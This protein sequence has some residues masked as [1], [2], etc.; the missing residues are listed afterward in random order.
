MYADLV[1]PPRHRARIDNRGVGGRVVSGELKDGGA[2]LAVWV[3]GVESQLE[4]GDMNGLV[5]FGDP[6]MY[7]VVPKAE[8]GKKGIR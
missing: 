2:G 5:A 4:G 6:A 1:C 7:K 3:D 8:K